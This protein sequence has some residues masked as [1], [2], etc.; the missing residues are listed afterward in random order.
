MGESSIGLVARSGRA[1]DRLRWVVRLPGWLRVGLLADAEAVRRITAFTLYCLFVPLAFL[2]EL[3]SG[4]A[5][6]HPALVAATT[7]FLVAQAASVWLIRPMPD[8][9]W[10]F[11]ITAIPASFV[12]YAYASSS[13]GEALSIVLVVPVAWVAVFLSVRM[14][15]ASVTLNALALAWLALADDTAGRWLTF[16]VRALT[17]AV[18]AFALHLLVVA[19]RRAQHQAERRADL[20][21]A[22]GLVSRARMLDILDTV[23]LEGNRPAGVIVLDIDHFKQVNDRYG[24]LAGDQALRDVAHVLQAV[25]REDDVLARW[26]GEEFLLL[27]PGVAEHELAAAAEKLRKAVEDHPFLLEGARVSLTISVGAAA[28]RPGAA[29]RTV[30]AA[31]DDALYQ[32]KR[33]GRNQT[34]VARPR[35][36]H[37]TVA[38]RDQLDAARR[39]V[40]EAA[41]RAALPADQTLDAV[42][43]VSEACMRLLPEDDCDAE[44]AVTI[45]DR[46]ETFTIV[47][48]DRAGH[49][50]APRNDDL[51]VAILGRVGDEIRFDEREAVSEVR[52]VFAKLVDGHP[53]HAA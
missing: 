10:L 25:V 6:H 52:I 41:A 8:A 21:A 47:V 20:D 37:I 35:L 44:L 53:V 26:G 49:R 1:G 31:A 50:S 16:A 32:A 42:I 22:T 5:G 13:A 36:N 23:P 39:A 43:A 7:T 3:V 38:G 14:V 45:H 29:M 48:E 18:I 33:G 51:N 46:P 11:L 30:V 27:L 4:G 17:L 28:A 9:G 24:H 2:L 15:S 40:E 19:L 12:A 34:V